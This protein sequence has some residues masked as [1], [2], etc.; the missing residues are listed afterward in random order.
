MVLW[1]GNL[2]AL[3]DGNLNNLEGIISWIEPTTPEIMG[4]ATLLAQQLLPSIM[5]YLM[6]SFYLRQTVT[7]TR[8][9]TNAPNLDIGAWTLKDKGHSTTLVLV[10]NMGA[11]PVTAS[12]GGV[13]ESLVDIL[14]RSGG[15]IEGMEGAVT[16]SLD[17][18]GAVG[19]IL[20]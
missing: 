5:P 10:A 2:F 15:N 12:L 7:F 19:F 4:A 9:T 3:F 16:V 1:V 6:P 8:P 17:R 14:L 13:G 20:G 18:E 11:K